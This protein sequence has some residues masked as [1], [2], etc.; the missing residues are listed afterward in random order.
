MS[1]K[2]MTLEEMIYE[3]FLANQKR[4]AHECDMDTDD[5]HEYLGDCVFCKKGIYADDADYLI[6]DA[7]QLG[8]CSKCL[9]KCHWRCF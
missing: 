5:P 8:I 7:E 6:N 4:I 3:D 1:V 9:N 2:S